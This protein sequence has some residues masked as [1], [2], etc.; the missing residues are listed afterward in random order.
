MNRILGTGI[1]FPLRP[2]RRGDLALAHG[3]QDVEQAIELILS[4]APGERPMR[5]E[6]GC[7]VHDFVFD[8]IDAD[9]VGRIEHAVRMA[10]DRWEP[11][12][13]VIDVLFDFDAA[14][15][16]ELPIEIRY[17]LRATSD[18]RNLV[19]PF[20]VIPDDEDDDSKEEG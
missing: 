9:T 12:I 15:R 1:S 13:E 4:T 2:D 20:Y 5:P 3:E 11:R 16:G 6:F 17:T 14:D 8:R 10:L 18:V 7:S 19:F